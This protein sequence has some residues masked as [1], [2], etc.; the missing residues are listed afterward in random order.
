MVCIQGQAVADGKE[1]QIIA[2]PLPCLPTPQWRVDTTAVGYDRQGSHTGWELDAE[3]KCFHLFKSSTFIAG[4]SERIS[5]CT[6][7]FCQVYLGIRKC[8]LQEVKL[9]CT[10]HAEHELIHRIIEWFVLEGTFKITSSNPLP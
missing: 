6:V 2:F 9:L 1:I 7:L 3:L 4:S 8:L 10:C 5:V